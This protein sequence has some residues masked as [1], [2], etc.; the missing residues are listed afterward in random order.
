MQAN[1]IEKNYDY[2]RSMLGAIKPLR[3]SLDWQDEVTQVVI[4]SKKIKMFYNCKNGL[5]LH[6]ESSADCHH[7]SDLEVFAK[8]KTI[9]INN[10]Y[11]RLMAHKWSRSIES[12]NLSNVRYAYEVLSAL[13]SFPNLKRLS[14]SGILPGNPLELPEQLRR[15]LTFLHTDAVRKWATLSGCEALECLC[16]N[17]WREMDFAN[18]PFLSGVKEFHTEEYY[19]PTLDGIYSMPE[20]EKLHIMESH[21]SDISAL[22]EM[23]K[24]RRITLENGNLYDLSPLRG[25]RIDLLNISGNIV[26]DLSPL[27]CCNIKHLNIDL[28]PISSL[29]PLAGQE[30]LEVLYLHCTGIR[31]LSPLKSCKNLK[32]LMLNVA[33]LPDKRQLKE[34]SF[35][36]YINRQPW[37]AFAEEYSLND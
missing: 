18:M 14:T 15:R 21:V 19:Q 35:I 27:E 36:P 8:L 9:S 7:L 1:N 34:L 24:L 25:K 22:A 16:L 11:S 29:E 6:K 5:T 4:D 23:P 33:H 26:E 12:I 13:D 28:N 20:L 10:F 37:T 32:L 3:L 2:Y 31:D 30:D 17:N